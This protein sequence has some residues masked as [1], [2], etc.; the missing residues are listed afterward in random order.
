MFYPI[1][2]NPPRKEI[3]TLAS[4]AGVFFFVLFVSFTAGRERFPSPVE[5]TFS[6]FFRGARVG[7]SITEYNA[8]SSPDKGI[9][10][11]FAFAA[12]R[13]PLDCP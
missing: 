8:T 13:N 2:F 7:F 10:T 11:G 9:S 3:F 5:S 1:S 12:L 4:G 6:Q